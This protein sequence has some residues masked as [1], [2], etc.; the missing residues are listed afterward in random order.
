MIIAAK[1]MLMENL[2]GEGFGEVM[3]I[4]RMPTLEEARSAVDEGLVG[5]TIAGRPQ[6]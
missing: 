1:Q 5:G 3:S 2:S 6:L 4:E